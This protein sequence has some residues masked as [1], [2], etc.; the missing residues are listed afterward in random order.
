MPPASAQTALKVLGILRAQSAHRSTA[1]VF[2][3]TVRDTTPVASGNP[4]AAG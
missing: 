2:R 1:G 3:V 4:S